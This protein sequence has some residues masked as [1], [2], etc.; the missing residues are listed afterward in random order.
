MS[1]N[2]QK[3]FTIKKKYIVWDYIHILK[4]IKGFIFYE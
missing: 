3:F 2:Y 1:K 4:S